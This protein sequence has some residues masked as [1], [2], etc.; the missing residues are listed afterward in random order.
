[1][2]HLYALSSLGSYAICCYSYISTFQSPRVITL[3]YLTLILEVNY[4]VYIN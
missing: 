1:M 2:A 3:H 4:I